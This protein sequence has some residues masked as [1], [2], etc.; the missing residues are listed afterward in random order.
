MQQL[1]H[2]NLVRNGTAIVVNGVDVWEVGEMGMNTKKKNALFGRYPS[3]DMLNNALRFIYQGKIDTA[4]AEIV[5]AIEKAH[6]YFH[7]DVVPIVEKVKSYWVKTHCE[8]EI[9]SDEVEK[10]RDE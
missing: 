1:S 6:G 10:Q 9:N 3:C 4:C 8:S 7:E 2:V 5:L